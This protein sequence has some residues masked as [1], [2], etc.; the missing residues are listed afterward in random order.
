M[1]RAALARSGLFVLLGAAALAIAPRE[2]ELEVH[3]SPRGGCEGQIVAKI[4][5][6]RQA[7]LVQAYSFT[8]APIASA[9]VG[10][11]ARG[12]DVRV[13]LDRSQPT[14]RGSRW[15]EL[16]A[17]GVPTS[18]DA[19]HAIAHNKLIVIDDAIVLTGSYNFTRSAEHANA[20]NL[21][22]VRSAALAARYA[23]NWRGHQ[24]HST[25]LVRRR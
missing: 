22:T 9:L 4:G 20:E 11:R 18:I 10:A 23:A 21:L 14:A 16:L 12:V 19:G 6:A 13:I 7:I 8:S 2:T 24:A 1:R 25:P 17:G 5:Q 15:P 3:F